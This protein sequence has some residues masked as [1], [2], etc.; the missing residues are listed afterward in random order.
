MQNKAREFPRWL[1]MSRSLVEPAVLAKPLGV[2]RA[3]I[4]FNKTF[5]EGLLQAF[6]LLE[7]EDGQPLPGALESKV[8]DD[9]AICLAY[10]GA[11]ATAI[12]METLI[13][14]GVD[15][16]VQVGT[17]GSISP[18][19]PIGDLIIPTWGIREEGTSYHYL[20]PNVTCRVS[21]G[22]LARLRG[23][24]VGGSYAEGGIWTTDALCRET[25]DK[26]RA[27]AEQGV[28]GVEMEW[29]ALQAIAT[30]RQVDFAAAMV[31]TDELF[32]DEWVQG[33]RS[34]PVLET[35]GWLCQAL[36]QGFQ[37]EAR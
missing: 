9:V 5:Y 22:A 8:G 18:T 25:E 19:C 27:Y 1:S 15:F 36:A 3:L 35:G 12:L 16:V 23:Y 24:L 28:L 34:E 17:A 20:P 29:T 11:P 30:V 14:S 13:A 21:E 10:F 6:E 33:F 31:I 2:R 26:V 32:G 4:S 37:K 7:A